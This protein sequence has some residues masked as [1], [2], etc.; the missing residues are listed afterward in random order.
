[1][2]GL[3]LWRPSPSP[4]IQ[5]TLVG[6]GRRWVCGQSRAFP[7]FPRAALAVSV[8]S[9]GVRL[10]DCPY[11][12]GRRR[13]RFSR[14]CPLLPSPSLFLFLS[15][16]VLRSH[17]EVIHTRARRVKRL[18]RFLV[19][20]TRQKTPVL[21]CQRGSDGSRPG[22]PCLGQLDQVLNEAVLVRF[23]T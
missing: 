19:K 10:A 20:D 4:F 13:F 9:A 8:G 15:R 1:M 5:K 12:H 23:C 22:N 18:N 6:C 2:A 3:K 17:G 11:I 21:S 7:R 16:L 14:G